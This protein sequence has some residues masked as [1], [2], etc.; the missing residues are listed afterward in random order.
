MQQGPDSGELLAVVLICK[1]LTLVS[2]GASTTCTG[3]EGIERMAII[4]SLHGVI[5]C[6]T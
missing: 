5:A 3:K 2:T 6:S 4:Y 1:N